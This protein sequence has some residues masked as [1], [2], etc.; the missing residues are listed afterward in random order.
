MRG[1]REASAARGSTGAEVGGV[2]GTR[3]LAGTGG[4][5][6]KFGPPSVRQWPPE[7]SEQKSKMIRESFGCCVQDTLQ[8]GQ[9]CGCSRD[10]GVV[11]LPP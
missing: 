4:R 1:T 8:A 3:T 7:D 11:R 10:G 5:Y 6:W 2:V 9:G